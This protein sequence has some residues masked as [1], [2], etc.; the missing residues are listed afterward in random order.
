MFYYTH[1]LAKLSLVLF[2]VFPFSFLEVNMLVN[3]WLNFVL[4]YTYKLKWFLSPAPKMDS[5]T[6]CPSAFLFLSFQYHG[7]QADFRLLI[8]LPPSPKGWDYRCTSLRLL[9]TVLGLECS[10]FLHARQAHCQL[11]YIL[12]LLF[13]SQEE[14]FV[15]YDMNYKTFS[16]PMNSFE[17]LF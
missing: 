14:T 12:V 7:A 1:T 9:D 15:Q 8:L 2:F 3:F 16:H 11:N 17:V 10:V 6:L 5:M 13:V 4:A